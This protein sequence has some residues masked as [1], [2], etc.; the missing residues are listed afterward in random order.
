M[1]FHVAVLPHE[2]VTQPRGLTLAEHGSVRV[3][4]TRVD[5]P[6]A[7]GHAVGLLVAEASLVEHPQVDVTSETNASMDAEPRRAGDAAHGQPLQPGLPTASRP[8]RPRALAGIM[9]LGP[10]PP[11]VVGDLV[12]VPHSDHRM[13]GVHG[14]KVTVEPVA[15]VSG[16]VVGQ[17][18]ALVCGVGVPGGYRAG[19]AFAQR[20]VGTVLVD[21]VA[22]VEHGINVLLCKMAIGREE[23]PVVVGAGHHAQAHRR[24]CI[25]RRGRSGSAD[26]GTGTE[27]AESVPVPLAGFEPRHVDV[28]GVVVA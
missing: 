6:C 7:E 25:D 10:T 8:R 15:P 21:V 12:V 20:T 11:G 28:H 19:Q 24:V 27:G 18:G 14:L 13:A 23:S 2:P 4:A 16:P 3:V 22:E 5:R 17:R 1:T 9:V 26:R